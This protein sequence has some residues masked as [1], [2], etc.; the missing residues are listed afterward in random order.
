[1]KRVKRRI[2]GESV[3]EQIIYNVSDGVKDLTGTRPRP[4]RFK[5]DAER[6]RHRQH[7]RYTRFERTVNCYPPDSLYATLTLDNEDEVHTFGEARKLA[8]NYI[9]RLVYHYPDCM[10][11]LVMGR[12]KHTDRIHFHMVVHG[13]PAEAVTR[14]YGL[15]DVVR[16][17]PLRE[18]NWYDGVDHGR[19][20]RGLA[21]YLYNHWTEEVGGHRWLG[22]RKQPKP[23]AEKPTE[24]RREYS[25]QK[26]PRPPK[27]YMLVESRSS[28]WGYLYFRYVRI[29]KPGARAPR[30]RQTVGDL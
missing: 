14:L 20:Y 11:L 10:A 15:G 23:E 29:P 16:V 9:R 13:V 7:L 3:C 22:T 2:F 18:H 6:E 8:R 26:P 5:S 12:G 1:M 21:L 4:P 25:V 19:D 28:E 17:V 27:G 30:K 24:C